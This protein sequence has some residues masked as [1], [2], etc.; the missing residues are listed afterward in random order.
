MNA[1]W[2]VF[3]YVYLIYFVNIYF[4]NHSHYFLFFCRNY[5]LFIGFFLV[6]LLHGIYHSINLHLIQF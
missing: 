3:I 6:L 1:A 4:N 2:V 5:K